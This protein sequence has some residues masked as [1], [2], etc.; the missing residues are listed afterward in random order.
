[1]FFGLEKIKNQALEILEK[2]RSELEV[3]G[4]TEDQFYET[5]RKSLV[6]KYNGEKTCKF[7]SEK[8]H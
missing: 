2:G 1:M 6:S 5:T 4:I 3:R 8:F 7:V